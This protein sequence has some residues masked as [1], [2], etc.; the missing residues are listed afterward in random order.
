MATASRCNTVHFGA[1][2][3]IRW[4]RPSGFVACHAVW[5]HVGQPILA[6]AAFQAAFSHHL[7]VH[8][9]RGHYTRWG[10]LQPANARFRASNRTL[11]HKVVPPPDFRPKPRPLTVLASPSPVHPALAIL[12]R[13]HPARPFPSPPKYFF[14]S[15]I[16]GTRS[17]QR[18]ASLPIPETPHR[19]RFCLRMS[20]RHNSLNPNGSISTPPGGTLSTDSLC[21]P[22]KSHV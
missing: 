1:C 19:Q 11:Q 12:P 5:H 16:G 14:N 3:G 21:G 17:P 18:Q 22:Q 6:A 20:L 9:P 13:I 8:L 4:D 7:S 15:Q 2:Q 10:R